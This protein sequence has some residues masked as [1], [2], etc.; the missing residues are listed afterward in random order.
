MHGMD[1]DDTNLGN[2]VH[3]I[4]DLGLESTLL[5]ADLAFSQR[6]IHEPGC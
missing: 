4:N 6:G 5:C 1:L 2:N 3:I